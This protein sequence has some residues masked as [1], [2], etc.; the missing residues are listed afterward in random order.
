MAVTH[1]ATSSVEST[2]TGV[3]QNDHTNLTIAAGSNIGLVVQITWVLQTVSGVSVTWDQGGTNQACAIIG[4]AVNTPGANG[5]VVLYG[6][7][8]P[9][10]GNH[11]LRV[12][13]TGASDVIVNAVAFN[14]V[15]QTSDAAAFAHATSATGATP[16][17][18][19]SLAITSAAAN[20][21]VELMTDDG[22]DPN[23][24]AGSP[25]AATQTH[26]NTLMGVPTG[27]SRATGAATETHSW[28]LGGT[29][30]WAQVGVDVVAVAASDLSV[31]SIGE[32]V[33]GGSTF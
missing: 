2:G 4:S 1:N 8:A 26:L 17:N 9:T 30:N 18:S 12:S 15:D 20:M 28:T 14:N 13:W 29:S 31:N 27:G 5:R 33:V 16:T 6:L 24:P 11:T 7:R 22:A 10:T 23:T 25:N 3:Q 21:T 19:P 32:P